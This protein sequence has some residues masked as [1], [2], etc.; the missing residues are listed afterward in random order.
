M[1]DFATNERL[2][3]LV[4]K[5]R[6]DLLATERLLRDRDDEKEHILRT[7]FVAAV[8]ASEDRTHKRLDDIDQHLNDQ[9]TLLNEKAQVW[10]TFWRTLL[11]FA[12]A[13]VVASLVL[14][15]GFHVG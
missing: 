7:E 8:Q 14:H 4:G 9:D 6:D 1:S 3:D 13:T 2:D 15:F 12:M 10:P 11:L 5:L